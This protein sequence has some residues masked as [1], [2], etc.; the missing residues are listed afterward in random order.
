VGEDLIGNIM[1]FK[2]YQIKI[3]TSWCLSVLEYAL[4]FVLKYVLLDKC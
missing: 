4:Q 1:C 3:I 2:L